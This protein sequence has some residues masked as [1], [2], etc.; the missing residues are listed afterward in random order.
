MSEQIH[1]E[2]SS[3]IQLLAWCLTWRNQL[4]GSFLRIVQQSEA[5]TAHK[6]C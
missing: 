4:F 6:V 2:C 3:Y 1:N 5:I